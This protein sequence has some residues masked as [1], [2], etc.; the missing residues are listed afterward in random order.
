MDSQKPWLQ[1]ILES[2]ARL[3]IVG[4]KSTYQSLI[5]RSHIRN[6][7]VFYKHIA[8]THGGRDQAKPFEDYFEIKVLKSYKKA[9]TKCVEEGTLIT[10]H[11]GEIL[12]LKSEWHQAK[13]IRT[14][15]RVLRGGADVLAQLGGGRQG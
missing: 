4:L 13:V 6:E 8:N 5:A 14:K 7:S 10:S 12:N 9:F 2:L 15:T 3:C 1:H 11:G